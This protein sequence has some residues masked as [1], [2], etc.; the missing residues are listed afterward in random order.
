ME[1]FDRIKVDTT[2]YLSG[3][4]TELKR[5]TWPERKDTVKSTLVVVIITAFFA[6]FFMLAD[7]VF[8]FLFGLILS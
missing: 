5:I 7:Y 8:S 4:A 1:K 6:L 3:V 2:R